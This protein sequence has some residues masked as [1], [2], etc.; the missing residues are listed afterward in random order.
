MPGRAPAPGSPPGS[1]VTLAMWENRH[2]DPVSLRQEFDG[3]KG[4]AWL[5]RWLPTRAYE[6]GV[7]AIYSNPIGIDGGTVKPGGSMVLDPYGEVLAECRSFDDEVVVA[8]CTPRESAPGWRYLQA[9]RP[10]LYGVMMEAREG[11]AETKP[12][13]QRSFDKPDDDSGEGRP[14]L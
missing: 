7:Y 11:P 2:R 13:W 9:R 14:R 3:P 4:R 12:G 6:N 5:H 10:E 8:L 1:S